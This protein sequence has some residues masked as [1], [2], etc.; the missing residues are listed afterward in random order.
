MRARLVTAFTVLAAIC[1]VCFGAVI[2]SELAASRT[3]GLVVERA[4]DANRFGV[5]AATS[6][7][8][9]TDAAQAYRDSTNN[10]ILV[11]AADGSVLCE[12]DIDRTDARV[13]AATRDRHLLEMPRPL[14][15]WNTEE[16]FVAQPIGIAPQAG[17]VVVIAVSTAVTRTDIVVRWV[18]LACVTATALLIFSGLALLVAGWILRPVTGLLRDVDALSSTLPA[19]SVPPRRPAAMSEGPPEILMLAAGVESVTRAVAA[20][21]ASERQNVIDTAHSLRN[22]LAALAVRLQALQPMLAADLA[23]ATFVSVVSEVDRLTELLDG[24]LSSAVGAERKQQVAAAA[25]FD[26]IAAVAERVGFWRD[27]YLRADIVLTCE[28]LVDT[29]RTSVP[30][31]VLAQIL[32]V[33]LSNSARY[34]GAG[35]RTTVTVDRESESVVI[36]VADTGVGVSADEL[37]LITTRFFRGARAAAG[38][39]GLGLPIAATLAAQYDGLM[40][41][42]SADPHGLVVTVTLPAIVDPADMTSR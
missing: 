2:A 32:D 4:H 12:V 27:A 21:A 37:D 22:P 40:F 35:S 29:A 6:P 3:R 10:G 5:L 36:S 18:Q 33:A 31:S 23:A 15:P 16:V 1:M 39:S 13:L 14:Y 24:L 30:A 8:G 38:G 26:A 20:L 17:G 19:H 42:E 11:L 9:L 34:A 41:V 25:G 28:P 7:A